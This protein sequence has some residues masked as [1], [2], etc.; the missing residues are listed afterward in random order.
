MRKFKT[1]NGTTLRQV[2]RWLK[3]KQAYNISP[4]NGMYYYCTDEN[5]YSPSSDNFNPTNGT[6]VDYFELN[7]KKWPL[8]R[9][10]SNFSQFGYPIFFYNEDDKLSFIAG[11]DSEDYHNPLL[12]EMDECGECVRCFYE[13]T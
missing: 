1:K 11:Y 13:E 6:S 5:G 7:K 9:F 10:I 4:R 8:N 3:V 2:S 12:I